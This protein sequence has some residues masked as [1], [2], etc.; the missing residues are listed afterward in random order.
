M[1][2]PDMIALYWRVLT[3]H[4]LPDLTDAKMDAE[5]VEYD[6]DRRGAA[7]KDKTQ[8]R[9]ARRLRLVTVRVCIAKGETDAGGPETGPAVAQVV[10]RTAVLHPGATG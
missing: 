4:D 3:S 6:I 8:N 10:C 5:E 1:S 9:A 7:L 2:A